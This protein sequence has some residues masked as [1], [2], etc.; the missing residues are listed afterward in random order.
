[1]LPL[2]IMLISTFEYYI[3]YIKNTGSCQELNVGQQK[4]NLDS[5]VIFWYNI[6]MK[7]KWTDKQVELL[8]RFY[9]ELTL[10]ELCVI[11]EKTKPAIY[12]KVHYLRKRGWTFT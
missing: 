11:L 3:Y 1:M 9:G 7:N 12:S 5:S 2:N 6:H 10:D 8:K 4:I